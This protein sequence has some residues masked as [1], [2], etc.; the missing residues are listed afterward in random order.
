MKDINELIAKLK[1]ETTRDDKEAAFKSIIDEIEK[2]YLE[3]LYLNPYEVAIFLANEEKTILS[4]ACPSYLVNSGMI[5]VS[6]TEAF[7]ASIYRSGRGIIEN[8]L[9]QQKHL[10]IFEIIRTPEG[11]IMPVWK[12]VG[13]IIAVENEKIGVIELSRRAVSADEAGED[14]SE[15]ELQF[16]EK[17]IRILAPYLKRVMP[18]DFRGK[19]T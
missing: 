2:Y 11:K 5:P 3:N 18:R 6:S 19:I 14:F 8:N 17:T 7:T 10:G 9:Q 13:A 1:M 12:M 4:F 16:L 15:R